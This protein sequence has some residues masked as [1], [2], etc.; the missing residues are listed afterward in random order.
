MNKI[1]T[2]GAL[3]EATAHLND[4]DAV[5]VEIHEGVRHEDLYTF[6]VDDSIELSEGVREVRFCI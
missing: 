1:L 3:R 2:I 4:A 5:V 6:S